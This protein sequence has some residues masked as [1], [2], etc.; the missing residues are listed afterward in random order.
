M[1]SRQMSNSSQCYPW[2]PTDQDQ[3]RCKS[4]RQLTPYLCSKRLIG[5]G[6]RMHR[7]QCGLAGGVQGCGRVDQLSIECINRAPLKG[8]CS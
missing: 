7:D 3:A 4:V 6:A 1:P 8:F 2:A 5:R